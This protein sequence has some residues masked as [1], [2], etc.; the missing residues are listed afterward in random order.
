MLR[1]FGLRPGGFNMLIAVLL[2]LQVAAERP[3]I[4]V[5]PATEGY[6]ADVASFDV[7][8]EAYVNAEI[9][10]KAAALCAD[11]RIEWGKFGSEAIVEKDP[12]KGS[13]RISGFFKE[14]RCVIPKEPIV[15]SISSDWKASEADDADVR[16]LFES[17]YA[18]RDAGNFDGSSAMLSPDVRP[19]KS[20]YAGLS[21][22]NRALETGSRRIT[23]VTWYVNPASA[24]RLGAYAALD[25]VGQYTG[26]HLYCGYLMLYRRGPGTYEIIREEQN[27]FH[28]N[29]EPVDP[30]QLE[31]MRSAM[32]R[33]D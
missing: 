27:V 30:A 33:G 28:R 17:Y 5:G 13:P 11:K 24:P 1:L 4:K 2:A 8:H 23:G 6:R 14:F 10:R 18:Q 19:D 32:C 29:A 26:A 15:A 25:F 9:G 7:S 20:D 3:L 31:Q 22:F 16:R 12:A 21:D